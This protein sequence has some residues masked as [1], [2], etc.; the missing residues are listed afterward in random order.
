MS[1][2]RRCHLASKTRGIA[3]VLLYLRRAWGHTGSPVPTSLVT[4]VRKDTDGRV[5]PYTVEEL[6][7]IK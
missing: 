6:M 1:F 5:D 4:R 3:A 2:V 7:K